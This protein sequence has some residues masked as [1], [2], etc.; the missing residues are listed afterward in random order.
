MKKNIILGLIVIIIVI[1]LVFVFFRKG[2]N[3]NNN[4][5]IILFSKDGCPHCANVEEY[6]KANNIKEKVDFQT[7]E[8]GSNVDNAELLRQKA[9]ICNIPENELGVP[10]LWDGS[11]CYIGDQDIIKFFKDRAG[12]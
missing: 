9:I 6:I 4:S 1:G 7:K 2:D 10:F 12:L 11:T 3:G 8:V 5:S